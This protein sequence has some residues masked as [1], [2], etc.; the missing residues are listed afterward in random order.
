MT[1][2]IPPRNRFGVDAMDELKSRSELGAK[3]LGH[4]AR[5]YLAL[6][7]EERQR[8][9][10]SVPGSRNS[11][12]G[13]AGWIGSLTNDEFQGLLVTEPPAVQIAKKMDDD[14]RDG[15]R[16]AIMDEHKQRV[17]KAASDYLENHSANRSD[18]PAP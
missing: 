16:Y 6:P 11:G 13:M 17:I 3:E 4:L 9:G 5:H 18:T 2:V 14:E 8:W 12:P 15:E 10:S 7:L 1:V